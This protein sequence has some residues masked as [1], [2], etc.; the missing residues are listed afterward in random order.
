MYP[1]TA[2]GSLIHSQ[3]Q[4]INN[5]NVT[6]FFF[7]ANL[8]MYHDTVGSSIHNQP[9][10]TITETIAWI[11]TKSHAYTKLLNHPREPSI[12]LLRE[13]GGGGGGG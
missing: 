2:P 6:N 5:T 8:C 4:L 3:L 13:E 9:A 1:T 11:Q 12:L 7:C 10:S